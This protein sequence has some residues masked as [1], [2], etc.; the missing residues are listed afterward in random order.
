MRKRVLVLVVIG[1][2]ILL[3]CASLI[4]QQATTA[5]SDDYIQLVRKDLRSDKKSLVAANM[6][7][8]ESEATKFW[9]V[10]DQYTADLTK[11]NDN[12]LAVIKEYAAKYE[13]LSSEEAQALV[14]KWNEAD[15]AVIQLRLKYLPKFQDA[16][17]NKK[18]ARFF[19]LDRR[20]G[21]VTDL[22]LASEIP[23]VEQ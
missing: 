19:Q 10:Y 18:T 22:Q 16:L 7:L 20:I 14:R 21:L 2:S 17:H 13:N 23:L 15:D 1:G 12:K 5:V 3:T 6:S 9:P 8:T 4:A 11:I